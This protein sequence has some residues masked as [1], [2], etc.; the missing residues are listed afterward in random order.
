[1]Q[2]WNEKADLPVGTKY[3]IEYDYRFNG[4]GSL[5]DGAT[6]HALSAMQ[7][8]N[9]GESS[10]GY[11]EAYINDDPNKT[12]LCFNNDGATFTTINAG[13]WHKIC[14]EIEI[15]ETGYTMGQRLDGVAKKTVTST[16]SVASI[17]G[18]R[19]I[20]NECASSEHSY[21]NFVFAVIP[22]VA[23]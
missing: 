20:V 11:I 14:F 12:N 21:D 16:N 7:V 8:L 23:E 19:A 9:G 18:L 10:I 22:P 5:R 17:L 3:L 4:H 2:I 13:E 1:M 15:T 6:T